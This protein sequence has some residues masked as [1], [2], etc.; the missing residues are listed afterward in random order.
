M[1]YGGFGP[2]LG[3][4]QRAQIRREVRRYRLEA[5]PAAVPAEKGAGPGDPTRQERPLARG[6]AAV[7]AFFG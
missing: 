6:A 2:E 1:F 5:R 3:R 7:A 4:E